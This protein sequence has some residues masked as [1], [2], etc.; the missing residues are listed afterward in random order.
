MNNPKNTPV[1]T[2]KPE[3][4][5]NNAEYSPKNPDESELIA[6]NPENPQKMPDDYLT[7]PPEKPDL[8]AEWLEKINKS[9]V[10]SEALHSLVLPPR[11]NII[12]NWFLEGDLGFIFAPR[13]MGKTWFALYAAIRISE[14]K[15]FWQYDI[16][17]ARRVLYIDGE[18]PFESL[19]QRHKSLSSGANNLS[20]LHHEQLFHEANAVLNL[21]APAIQ[22]ALMKH[23]LENKIEVIFLDNLSCLFSGLKENEGDSWGE[24]VLPWLLE[25]RRNRIAV[26]IIHHAGRNGAMRGTS[27]RED[28]AFWV[29]QLSQSVTE[30]REENG[31][32]FVATFVKNRNTTD[33]DVPPFSCIF[34]KTVSDTVLP[35]FHQLDPLQTLRNC[36]ENMGLD[37]ATD[38]SDEIGISKGQV[39]KLAKKA[40]DAGWLE[41]DG[42]YYKIKSV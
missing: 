3:L 4:I 26:V 19:R 14:G 33:E 12:G 7:S 2:I 40:M 11:G 9:V 20:F 21:S 17:Q 22:Q 28:A 6:N 38:I 42:R 25:L 15:Q 32:H 18:M 39:S 10:S 29:I 16:P 1:N 35:V 34:K 31:A 30:N 8:D 5:A 24:K 36:I 13:G 23:C 41:K 27:R 37:S